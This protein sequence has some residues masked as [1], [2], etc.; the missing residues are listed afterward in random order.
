MDLGLGVVRIADERICLCEQRGKIGLHQRLVIGRT[1]FRVT[2]R[3]KVMAKGDD[4]CPMVAFQTG[5]ELIDVQRPIKPDRDHRIP[6]LDGSGRPGRVALCP[7]R[8]CLAARPKGAKRPVCQGVVPGGEIDRCHG[9]P[10]GLT[11]D[12]IGFARRGRFQPWLQDHRAGG[13][14]EKLVRDKDAIAHRFWREARQCGEQILLDPH[15]PDGWPSPFPRGGDVQP[16]RHRP[17]AVPRVRGG[18]RA[19][20]AP[21]DCSTISPR[22][23]RIT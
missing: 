8:L 16:E 14:F 4:P 2:D 6:R 7:V 1:E 3:D 19:C 18:Y 11:Q 5:V 12:R 10:A 13:H 23:N 17:S 22:S 20:C 15:D 9:T 21:L